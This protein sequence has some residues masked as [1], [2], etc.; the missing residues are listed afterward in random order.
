MAWRRRRAMT[1]ASGMNG[2]GLRSTPEG[3]STIDASGASGRTSGF[4][5]RATT[6]GWL[7]SGRAA[8]CVGGANDAHDVREPAAAVPVLIVWRAGRSTV[9][10]SL[11]N[12]RSLLLPV[13]RW[14][15]GRRQAAKL[16]LEIQEVEEVGLRRDLERRHHERRGRLALRWSCGASSHSLDGMCAGRS[17]RGR[18]TARRA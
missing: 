4:G 8:I 16:K 2:Y 18:A 15:W 9:T 10:I 11:V 1:D 3:R 6:V 17:C 14:S 7:T 13:G 5:L 12:P